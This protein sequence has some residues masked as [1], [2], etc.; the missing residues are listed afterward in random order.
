[1]L[2]IADGIYLLKEDFLSEAINLINPTNLVLGNEFKQTNNKQI[3]NAID[4]VKKKKWK[5]FF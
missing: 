2:D 5:D 4:L 1:M 3:I